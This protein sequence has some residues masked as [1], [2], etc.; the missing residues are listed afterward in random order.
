MAVN[1]SRSANRDLQLGIRDG[2]YKNRTE[3]RGG[4]VDMSNVNIRAK[5]L[6]MHYGLAKDHGEGCTCGFC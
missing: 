5:E 3:D 4:E 6:P 2:R 1:E